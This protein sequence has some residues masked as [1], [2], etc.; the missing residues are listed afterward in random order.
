MTLQGDKTAGI[1]ST[2]KMKQGTVDGGEGVGRMGRGCWGK[3]LEQ[4]PERT[5]WEPGEDLG[6]G[7]PGRGNGPGKG[8]A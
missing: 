4:R 7:V 2:G 5:E 8:L 6:K 1:D 3:S